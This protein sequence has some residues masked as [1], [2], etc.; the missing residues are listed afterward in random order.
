MTKRSVAII[1]ARM[2][3]SRLPGKVLVDLCGRPVLEWIVRRA[4]RATRIDEVVVA[5]TI[6][7]E[8]DA[9][10]HFC[11]EREIAYARGSMHDV[12][13][14]YYQSAKQFDADLIVRITGD[15][16]LIDPEM[17]DANLTQF[18]NAI[19]RLDFAA[20]RLPEQRT[21]PI[22]LDAEYC[23]FDALEQAWKEAQAPHQREHVMPYFY[24]HPERFAIFHMQHEPNLGHLRWTV[25]TPEDLE[26]LRAICGHFQN[27]QFSWLEVLELFEQ[28]PDLAAINAQV[29]HKNQYDVDDRQ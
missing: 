16:P 21:I 24:E 7:V 23:T 29:A 17:L 20:N 14:R 15:C 25:D 26:L 28:Q 18:L 27:D 3:S 11:K 22:G 1:Q 5:T 8:D 13:D 4:R 19:P 2:A 6:S 10:A 12:L 9:I